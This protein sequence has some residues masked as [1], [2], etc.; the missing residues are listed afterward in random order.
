MKYN[1]VLNKAARGGLD[2]DDFEKFLF[3][4][5]GD[6]KWPESWA[7]VE[8]TDGLPEGGISFIGTAQLA[9]RV[10]HVIL[11]FLMPG[12]EVVYKPIDAEGIED[13]LNETRM[14]GKAQFSQLFQLD[15]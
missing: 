11:S 8:Q 6:L 4:K 10:D 5:L 15:E 1:L 2:W 9:N 12:T 3:A 13:W 14:H 7:R